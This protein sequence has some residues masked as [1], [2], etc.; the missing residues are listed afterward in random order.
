VNILIGFVRRNLSLTVFLAV[1]VGILLYVSWQPTEVSVRYTT[2]DGFYYLNIAN[3]I[4]L[5]KG[6][7]FDGINP[8]N[9]YHPLWLLTIVP[10][11]IFAPESP[12]LAMHVCLTIQALLFACGV[13]IL[14]ITLRRFY[15]T[16]ATLIGL[17][18]LLNPWALQLWTNLLESSIHLFVLALTV[19]YIT[20]HKQ[21]LLTSENRGCKFVLGLLLGLLFLARIESALMTVAVAAIIFLSNFRQY[22][23]EKRAL[24]FL[25]KALFLFVGLA[26]PSAPYLLWN[27]V[28]FRHIFPISAVIKGQEGWGDAGLLSKMASARRNIPLL[29]E[30][31]I[32]FVCVAAAL[33]LAIFALFTKRETIRRARQ[34]FYNFDFLLLFAVLHAALLLFAARSI[35]SW[36]VIPEWILATVFVSASFEFLTH[37]TSRKT[38]NCIAVAAAIALSVLFFCVHQT[39]LKKFRSEDN[40]MAG[41][42]NAALWVEKNIREDVVIGSWDAGV[43]GYFSRR[44]VINLDGLV[45]NFE[46]LSYMQRKEIPEYLKSKG[47]TV[48]VQGF[49]DRHLLPS[50]EPAPHP[51]Y[52]VLRPH[53]GRELHRVPYYFYDRGVGASF[54]YIWEF[55][56]REKK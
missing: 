13:I 6:S 53:L 37:T 25:K 18:V 10:V 30:D 11:F 12:G 20:D 49:A 35:P 40:M 26:V 51:H 46:Y 44:P 50:G 54:V 24:S 22:T 14:Y 21:E 16:S 45:N 8:T 2:D 36:Y 28:K 48:I 17:M 9:G 38:R 32:F 52:E 3:N 7:S 1:S 39:H 23:T 31:T 5:G 15:S 55:R 56:Y 41:F 27:V 19:L 34:N 43:I 42:Y 33:A 29:K 4:A 47:V